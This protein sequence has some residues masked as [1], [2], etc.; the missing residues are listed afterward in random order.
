MNIDETHFLGPK[1]PRQLSATEQDLVSDFLWKN[2]IS[3]LKEKNHPSIP[4]LIKPALLAM[5]TAQGAHLEVA[6][7]QLLTYFQDDEIIALATHLYSAL[8][9]IEELNTLYT[10]ASEHQEEYARAFRQSSSLPKAFA[11][12]NPYILRYHVFGLHNR[13][14]DLLHNKAAYGEDWK[15]RCIDTYHEAKITMQKVDALLP[16]HPAFEHFLKAYSYYTLAM[17]IKADQAKH[18]WKDAYYQALMT[19]ATLNSAPRDAFIITLGQGLFK[20]MPYDNIDGLKTDLEAHLTPEEIHEL[21]MQV[22]QDI[23]PSS[24]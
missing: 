4:L 11:Q 9:L 24:P 17:S 16:K 21:V 22:E 1:G 13:M 10:N 7:P 19:E 14:F 8:Q 18:Y 5:I 20:D 6:P 23:R 12:A 3:D 15:A 2:F